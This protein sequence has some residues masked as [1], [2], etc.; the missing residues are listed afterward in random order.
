MKKLLLVFL[1]VPLL[2]FG[3]TYYGYK[4]RNNSNSQSSDKSIS[5]DDALD[6]IKY[7]GRRLD[8]SFGGYDSKAID[9]ISWYKW[10]DILFA[11]VTFKRKYG[12]EY[13]YG[14]WKYKYET[15]RDIKN[16]FEESESKG[17]FFNEYIRQATIYC[18]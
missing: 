3:H 13:I 1:F 10:E 8:V 17:S 14:G 16:A 2:S 12:K 5:C 15:Y 7:N 6:K 18:N 4:A 11:L 9:K